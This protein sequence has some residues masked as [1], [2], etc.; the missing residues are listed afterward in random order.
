M[1][2]SSLPSCYVYNKVYTIHSIG[3][4]STH[5]LLVVLAKNMTMDPLMQPSGR[6]PLSNDAAPSGSYRGSPTIN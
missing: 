6:F 3:R 2:L 5:R 4:L 1:I